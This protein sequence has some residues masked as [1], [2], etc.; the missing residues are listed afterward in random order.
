MRKLIAVLLVAGCAVAGGRSFAADRAGIGLEWGFGPSLILGGGF[1]MLMDE[2]AALNWEVSSDFSVSVFS[3]NGIWR[4]SKEYQNNATPAIKH[5]ITVEGSDDLMGIAIVHS[6]PGISFLK[7]GIELGMMN[8]DE[9]NVLYTNSDGSAGA[10]ADFGGVRDSINQTASLEGIMAKVTLL[11][12][13]SKGTYA[14][15]SVMGSLRFVQLPTT[16]LY[17]TQ[18]SDSTASPLKAIDPIA[19]YN[20]LSIKLMASLGF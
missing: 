4:G 1:S 20:N 11:K 3:G 7:I 10:L 5:K 13:E 16:R 19:S 14:D 15:V 18:E 6:M 12:G 2:Q 8:L 9:S 17:G